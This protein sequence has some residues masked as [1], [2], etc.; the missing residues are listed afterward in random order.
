MSISIVI[1]S[2]NGIYIVKKNLPKVLEILKKEKTDKKE[3]IIVDD[4]STDGSFEYLKDFKKNNSKYD[5]DIKVAQNEKNLGFSSNVNNGV[6]LAT[7]EVIILLNTD[8]IPRQDFIE[9]LLKHFADQDVFA[10]GCIDESLEGDR[11][12]LRG[13]GIGKWQRGFL[14]HRAGA[15][16][17]GNTLWVSGGSGAFRKSIWEKLGGFEELYNP[18]YWED[19]DLS[20]RALKSGYKI[21]FEKNSVVRHEHEKGTIKSHFTS[22]RVKKISYRNQIIFVWLNITEIKYLIY[23]IF[24]LPYHLVSTLLKGDYIFAMGLLA[25]IGRIPKIIHKRILSK[26]LFKFNDEEVL[27]QFSSEFI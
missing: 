19:I 20:Y 3:L 23:H 18:F 11:I 17:R 27:Q 25:A 10:V 15:L 14:V 26:K 21:I 6:K 8:V 22:S 9:P 4:K 24:W 5:V 16:D 1:P 7:G 12:V 2:Y 13:R